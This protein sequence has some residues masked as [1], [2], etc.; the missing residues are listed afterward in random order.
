MGLPSWGCKEVFNDLRRDQAEWTGNYVD[1]HVKEA[2][3]WSKQKYRTFQVSELPKSDMAELPK[4]MKP[5][6][7]AYVKKAI[8]QGLP[9]D[10]IL[11]D[12]IFSHASG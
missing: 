11:K 6:I 12:S 4:L 1:N 2:L 7:D 9:G 8:G 10:Q 3:D 5:V